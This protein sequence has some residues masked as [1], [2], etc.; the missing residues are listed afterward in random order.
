MPVKDLYIKKVGGV[1]LKPAIAL[2]FQLTKTSS[3]RFVYD[4]AK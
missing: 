4:H 2:V 1:L 3:T